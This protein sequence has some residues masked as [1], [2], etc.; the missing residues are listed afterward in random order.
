MKWK[1]IGYVLVGQ[2]S[3]PS[4]GAWIEITPLWL[5]CKVLQ[6]HPSRGAWIEIAK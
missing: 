5:V 2:V 1:P 3:H 6:S 4:R